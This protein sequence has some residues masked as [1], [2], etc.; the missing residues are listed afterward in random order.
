[1]RTWWLRCLAAKWLLAAITEWDINRSTR[2]SHQ[3]K[4]NASHTYIE[5][6]S[7]H[8]KVFNAIFLRPIDANVI[9]KNCCWRI[10]ILSDFLSLFGSDITVLIRTVRPGV[11]IVYND[12]LRLDCPSDDAAIYNLTIE[13]WR[14]RLICFYL[15]FLQIY[16]REKE[17]V[18]IFIY[19]LDGRHV[20]F[21]W[22]SQN[23][24]Q[25]VSSWYVE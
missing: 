1:M 7:V 16:K 20:V 4:M 19:W 8:F 12:G 22:N 24:I 21:G 14:Q 3:Y 5:D 13:T 17:A 23:Y 10:V 15:W 6:I 11:W 2:I 9:W 25:N 18:W